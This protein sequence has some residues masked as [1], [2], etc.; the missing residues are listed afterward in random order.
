MVESSDIVQS[1]TLDDQ[2]K[3]ATNDHILSLNENMETLLSGFQLILNIVR[4]HEK[5]LN[6]LEPMKQTCDD[7][8]EPHL[9]ENELTVG[10]NESV[11][12]VSNVDL[13][14]NLAEFDNLNETIPYIPNEAIPCT[15]IETLDISEQISADDDTLFDDI[16]SIA[17]NISELINPDYLKVNMQ[18]IKPTSN[19]VTDDMD[20]LS[21]EE[22]TNDTSSSFESPSYEG[23]HHLPYEVHHKSYFSLFKV[24]ELDMST[25]FDKH[26]ENRSVAFY[27]DFPYTYSN[28]THMPKP[29]ANN[30]YLTKLL[31]YVEIVYPE[32][33]F[34]SAMVHRYSSG[35]MHIP[36]HS[37]S[38]TEIADDSSIITISL[39]DTRT[40]N[41]QEKESS[42]KSSVSLHHGDSLIMTKSS[43]TFFSHGIPTEKSK[44]LRISITLRLLN[45]P[46][47]AKIEVARKPSIFT[48]FSAPTSHSLTSEHLKSP[49]SHLN[50]NPPRNYYKTTEAVNTIYISSSM[51][52]HLNPHGMSSDQQRAHVFFYPGATATQMLERLLNDPEFKV[53][54]KRKVTQIFLLSGTNNVDAV[55]SGLQTISDVSKSLSELLY[56]LWMLFDYAKINVVN[57]LP[58]EH[59]DKNMIVKQLN[60]FLYNECKMHGL[61]FVDTESGQEPMFSLSNG[62]RNNVLF[63]NGYDNVHL[64]YVGFS[65]IARYLK[66]LAHNK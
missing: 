24:N 29:F 41:F 26:F 30:T 13:E 20:T 11:F 25:E 16:S 39:G 15:P 21:I 33:K 1:M 57:I 44:D 19:S 17:T 43:Q 6:N 45:P 65:K 32:A 22:L 18:S 10:A 36:M 7:A 31:S 63:L 51:F 55:F 66:Y 56:K 59:S 46:N 3:A 4:N 34:N 47:A 53:L 60:Q 8:S 35:E 5:L 14:D 42:F 58:R 52:R 62:S 9:C 38:E 27:G 28:T 50:S 64:N 61:Q 2:F 23:L 49:K 40:F 54:D 37:D 48:P 12:D